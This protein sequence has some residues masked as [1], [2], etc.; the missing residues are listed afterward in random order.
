MHGFQRANVTVIQAKI[1]VQLQLAC[2]F[3]FSASSHQNLTTLLQTKGSE[4]LKNANL[5]YSA[6]LNLNNA[7]QH[8]Y[9]FCATLPATE[10]VDLRPDFICDQ[11]NESYVKAKV[12]LPPC[13]DEKYRYAKS[14]QAVSNEQFLN[15]Y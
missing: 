8:L 12:I 14:Q 15:E 9:H 11:I 13:V 4:D 5:R 6:L 10:Y 3:I 1:Q 7:L 2:P